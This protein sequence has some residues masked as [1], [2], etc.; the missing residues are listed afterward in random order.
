[1]SDIK[2]LSSIDGIAQAQIAKLNTQVNQANNLAKGANASLK[3]GKS[4]AAH[5]KEI[6]KAATQF[7]SLLV[8]EMLQ[9]MWKSVPKDGLIS[10]SNEEEIYQDMLH[11]QV[12]NSIAEN[13]SLGVKKVIISDIKKTESRQKSGS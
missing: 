11:E 10:G 6:E 4:P 3:S 1:M 8:H 13:Q 12:A 5:E 9:S 2:T 7:E